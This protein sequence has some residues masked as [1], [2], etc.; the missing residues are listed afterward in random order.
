MTTT[1][2]AELHAEIQG[3]EAQAGYLTATGRP[4]D[5]QQHR[6]LANDLRTELRQMEES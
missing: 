6:A 2:A 1:R 3:H 5:A 4:C